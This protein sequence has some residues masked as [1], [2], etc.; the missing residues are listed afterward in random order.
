VITAEHD[1]LRD[2]GEASAARLHAAGVGVKSRREAGL[3]HGF[4]T[5]DTISPACAAAADRIAGDLREWAVSLE[6][7]RRNVKPPVRR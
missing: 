6:M 1:P 2:K 7:P 5:L 4:I 3:I